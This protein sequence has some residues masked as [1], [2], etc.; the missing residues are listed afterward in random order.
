MHASI[1]LDHLS[2]VHGRTERYRVHTQRHTTCVGRVASHRSRRFVDELREAG[3]APALRDPRASRGEPVSG[4]CRPGHVPGPMA[5]QGVARLWL[6]NARTR[7]DLDAYFELVLGLRDLDWRHGSASG[8]AAVCTLGNA[9]IRREPSAA[10]RT[11]AERRESGTAVGPAG[12]HEYCRCAADSCTRL[13]ASGGPTRCER[14]D[15]V[16]SELS[17][18]LHLRL[19]RVRLELQ[20]PVQHR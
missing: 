15:R 11:S 2:R 16:R 14:H 13:R 18:R 8:C 7:K 20:S 4:V 12:C 17:L 9:A 1:E 3:S 6:A 19:G 5:V 10:V